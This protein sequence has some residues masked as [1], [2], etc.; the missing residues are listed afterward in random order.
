VRL[1]L[2]GAYLL[3]GRFSGGGRAPLGIE[4]GLGVAGEFL[5]G[6]LRLGAEYEFQYFNR[7]TDG[8]TGEV[9]VPIQLALVRLGAV[10]GF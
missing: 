4:I 8:G 1:G 10:V 7:K 2:R 5:R 6:R 9:S 3:A